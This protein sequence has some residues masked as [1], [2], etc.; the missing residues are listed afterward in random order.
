V[1]QE[2]IGKQTGV[3]G[4]LGTQRRRLPATWRGFQSKIFI[5]PPFDQLSVFLVADPDKVFAD[6]GV[7]TERDWFHIPFYFSGK[8]PVRLQ[9]SFSVGD[10]K[11]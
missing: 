10:R 1:G 7:T 4:N 3:I 2:R 8:A 9:G 5:V 6:T 11:R